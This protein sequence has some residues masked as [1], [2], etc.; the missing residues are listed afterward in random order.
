MESK[1]RGRGCIF[2]SNFLGNGRSFGN[3]IDSLCCDVIVVIVVVDISKE[4]VGTRLTKESFGG[5]VHS[6]NGR[7]SFLADAMLERLGLDAMVESCF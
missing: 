6:S 3:S 2:W 7:G 5:S 4:S 1:P